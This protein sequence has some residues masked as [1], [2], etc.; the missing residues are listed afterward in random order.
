MF[1]DIGK[2]KI[3]KNGMILSTIA[4]L[5]LTAVLVLSSNLWM[6]V[7]CS[8]V[9]LT[10]K[11]MQK[12]LQTSTTLQKFSLSK[13]YMNAFNYEVYKHATMVFIN[14]KTYSQCRFRNR[15]VSKWKV[16]HS[17]HCH[18]SH[19]R[20]YKSVVV[21]KQ[22]PDAQH[23]II[24]PEQKDT[25]HPCYRAV[26]PYCKVLR[27]RLVRMFSLPRSDAIFDKSPVQACGFS[28]ALHE[29]KSFFLNFS[30]IQF[31]MKPHLRCTYEFV[32]IYRH[33]SN[34]K[35][36][37]FC[38]KKHPWS[39]IYASSSADVFIVAGQT[40][41]VTFLYQV[42]DQNHLDMF[43]PCP[44]ALC[45]D[46]CKRTR[47]GGHFTL[48]PQIII[49][50]KSNVSPRITVFLITVQ[51]WAR[52]KF[53]FTAVKSLQLYD[54]PSIASQSVSLK[55]NSSVMVSSFQATL[56]WTSPFCPRADYT[57]SFNSGA[58]RDFSY[59]FF[60]FDTLCKMH[61]VVHE[62][63]FLDIG[64]QKYFNISIDMVSYQGPQE[65]IMMN[66]YGGISVCFLTSRFGQEALTISHNVS[67][68]DSRDR[69]NNLFLIT[70]S[71]TKYVVLVYYFFS[72]FSHVTAFLTITPTKCRA[73]HRWHD[74]ERLA[75]ADEEKVDF[76]TLTRRQNTSCFVLSLSVRNV[77]YRIY[78]VKYNR[79][80]NRLY[81]RYPL[82]T[83]V[84]TVF[85]K[86]DYNIQVPKGITL[87]HNHVPKDLNVFLIEDLI[88]YPDDVKEYLMFMRTRNATTPCSLKDCC[89]RIGT[90]KITAIES[91]ETMNIFDRIIFSTYRPQEYSSY[92]LKYGVTT[93]TSGNRWLRITVL[94]VPC[95]SFTTPGYILPDSILKW[96]LSWYCLPSKD[97][98]KTLEQTLTDLQHTIFWTGLTGISTQFTNTNIPNQTKAALV[99]D[100][101]TLYSVGRSPLS[102]LAIRIVSAPE[103]NVTMSYTG[104]FP[105]KRKLEF[106][107]LTFDVDIYIPIKT[108]PLCYVPVHLD[109]GSAYHRLYAPQNCDFEISVKSLNAEILHSFVFL[110]NPNFFNMSLKVPDYLKLHSACSSSS[111]TCFDKFFTWK[112]AAD[113][114]ADQGM[115]LPSV[116]SDRDTKAIQQQ[117]YEFQKHSSCVKTGSYSM[118]ILYQTVG[119]FVGLNF[120]VRLDGSEE[121][122]ATLVLV[123]RKLYHPDSLKVL[124]NDS[125]LCFPDE[126]ILLV[127]W[128][129]FVHSTL[130]SNG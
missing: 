31:D 68:A 69:K 51:K 50:F 5:N 35:Q 120:Q 75:W 130:V 72:Q 97:R 101:T 48:F 100:Y 45:A 123:L 54:G 117:V 70:Q 124:L 73:S 116:N 81:L 6:T 122:P 20:M 26:V 64:P 66:R 38:G 42:T 21:P 127:K 22:H 77:F 32:N 52:V 58:M 79:N 63:I 47:C 112:E 30:F 74:F 104:I 39:T 41:K 34:P 12:L 94:S 92:M 114:C 55:K 95:I 125:C 83:Q 82:Q 107:I 27:N 24:N 40:S 121:L 9:D 10:F 108:I 87:I 56:V 115:T 19:M 8:S 76:D 61:C 49:E 1:P 25:F 36:L 89:M 28:M 109:R 7:C 67:Y 103:T 65:E 90:E 33:S 119:I 128:Q 62:V 3:D 80:V 18:V 15:V 102:D 44:Y 14:P 129:S 105:E 2:N 84:E 106:E 16:L 37:L 78:Q 91:S 110:E 98:S 86:L 111:V 4:Q 71:D 60:S 96:L 13:S 29:H 46:H 99:E 53:S 88:F 113:L 85:H 126:Q 43:R 23:Y 17:S 11:R 57:G 93:T 118:E 59:L